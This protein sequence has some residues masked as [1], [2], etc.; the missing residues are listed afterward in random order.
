VFAVLMLC[1]AASL[2]WREWAVERTPR[3]DA[4]SSTI[5]YGTLSVLFALVP[6]GHAFLVFTADYGSGEGALGASF[7]AI[8]LLI[9]STAIS[10]GIA[11]ALGFAAWRGLHPSRTVG[12][13]GL[14]M[15]VCS[16]TPL[17]L[18]LSRLVRS[19]LGA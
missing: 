12:A 7:I 17:V 10:G 18:L 19:R 6:F 4:G 11:I 2:R 16:L 3:G 14:A 9:V 8:G 13:V 1:W 15:A 5:V